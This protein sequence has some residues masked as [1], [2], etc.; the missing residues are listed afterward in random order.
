MITADVR[1][2]VWAAAGQ[3]AAAGEIPSPGPAS[4]Q[5]GAGTRPDD[6]S[7]LRPVPA[8]GVPIYQLRIELQHGADYTGP[9]T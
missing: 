5:Q 6:A 9:E 8:S 2:A 1:H 7:T 3:A 4:G